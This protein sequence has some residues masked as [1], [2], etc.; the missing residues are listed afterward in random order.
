MGKAPHYNSGDKSPFGNGRK[1]FPPC[2]QGKK[3]TET[4]ERA[5]LLG[6][7]T[8]AVFLA[9]RV[10]RGE[11]FSSSIQPRRLRKTDL[12]PLFKQRKKVL[13]VWIKPLFEKRRLPILPAVNRKYFRRKRA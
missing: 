5:S 2:L 11:T 3:N 12:P 6:R 7:T 1:R 8:V 4:V 10:Q 13:P 9:K